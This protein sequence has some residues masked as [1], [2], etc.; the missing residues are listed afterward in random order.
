MRK[1]SWQHWG[2]AHA[3]GSLPWEHVGESRLV[4]LASDLEMRPAVCVF[5][6]PPRAALMRAP[7]W[8][9]PS[10]GRGV[11]TL[12]WERDSEERLPLQQAWL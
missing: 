9:Q 4:G 6:R 12:S 2:A 1:R 7:V 8:E 11:T 3:G 5:A 10:K